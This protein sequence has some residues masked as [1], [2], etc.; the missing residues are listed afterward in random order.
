MKASLPRTSRRSF[1]R[2]G[3]IGLGSTLSSRSNFMPAA[4]LKN[5]TSPEDFKRQL[6][7]PILSVPT[8]YTSDFKVDY[9]GMRRMIE[10]AAKAGVRV[11]ALTSGNNQYDRLTYDEIKQITRMLVETVAGRGVTI[12][13]TGPWWTGPAVDYAR[14]AE[15]VGAD[16]VQVLTPTAGD[17]E[18]K[19]E[20]YKAVAAATRLGLV[21]HG[22]ANLPLM[23]R[24]AEIDSVV[25]IKAEFTVDYTVSLYQFL[26][27]RWNIFQ[28][29]Q[30]SQFLAYVPYGMQ[31]YYSTFSTFAPEIAITFWGAVER[32]DLKKAGEIVLK[33][34][35]PFFQKWSHSFWRATLEHF[36]VASRYLRPPER[37]FTDAQVADVKEFFSGLGLQPK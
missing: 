9:D 16:A 7:G 25:A 29:G 1:L 27:G 13:A 35:V 37:T 33:Y 36:G 22:P 34:D 24:L 18:G 28:G 20:H 26:K 5:L 12:A 15:S 19:F 14:Y 23:K 6:R 17:D 2:Y 11:F 31:A 30:K 3:A 8:T 10:R 4:V 21:V 32:N